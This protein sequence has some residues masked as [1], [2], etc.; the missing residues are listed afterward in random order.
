MASTYATATTLLIAT[1]SVNFT[2]IVGKPTDDDIFNITKVLYPLL[3][4]LKYN[5]FT[6]AGVQDDNLIGLLQLDTTYAAA[7]GGAFARPANPGPYDLTIPDAAT[8]V[9]RNRMDSAHMVLINDFNTFEAAKEGIKAF[10]LA[11]IDETWLKP[12]RDATTFFN[13]VTAYTMLEFL[14]TNSGGLH[15]VDLAT[16]PSD[17]L[18]YYA[19]AEGIPKFILELEHSREKLE[20]GG[21]PKSDATLLA[22]A[23]SQ[24]M[25][26]TLSGSL[27]Q[28]GAN[29]TSSQ[30]V[31]SMAIPLPPCKHR[32][33][34]HP[35]IEP[36]RVRCSESRR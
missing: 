26:P 21:V 28:V 1:A 27:A 35:Q 9:V 4:S 17:M 36:T 22:T 33:G 8:P 11:N 30:N 23:H 34:S 12:L 3:H 24:V 19:T 14:R 13:N 7:S 5:E 25:A 6:V 16:L 31:G 15:D 29:G 10:L 32:T 2:P 20:R 18:H